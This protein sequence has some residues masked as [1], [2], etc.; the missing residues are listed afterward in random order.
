MSL[1]RVGL[2]SCTSLKHSA[3]AET[4]DSW[5]CCAL[6]SSVSHL[7]TFATRSKWSLKEEHDVCPEYSL[8]ACGVLITTT[9]TDD[10]DADDIVV[11]AFETLATAVAGTETLLVATDVTTG[12]P[13]CHS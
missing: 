11:G 7:L 1:Y 13:V 4:K 6:T 12:G 5:R 8:T 3:A 9:G 2:S 10:D